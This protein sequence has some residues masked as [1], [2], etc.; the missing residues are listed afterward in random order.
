[1]P[2][3]IAVF[4]SGLVSLEQVGPVGKALGPESIIPSVSAT[5]LVDQVQQLTDSLSREVRAT[6]ASA[7]C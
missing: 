2:P 7:E 4:G 6:M 3:P 5:A 1:M